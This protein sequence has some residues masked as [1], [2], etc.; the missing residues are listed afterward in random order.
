MIKTYSILISVAC[1]KQLYF[2]AFYS[3]FEEQFIL[4]NSSQVLLKIQVLIIQMLI[5]F[6]FFFFKQ[7]QFFYPSS[8]SIRVVKNLCGQYYSIYSKS[9]IPI[10]S[11]KQVYQEW[12]FQLFITTPLLTSDLDVDSVWPNKNNLISEQFYVDLFVFFYL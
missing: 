7:T 4:R 9:I 12:L 6:F 10:S 11:C 5:R 3:F 2:I 1:K 8:V